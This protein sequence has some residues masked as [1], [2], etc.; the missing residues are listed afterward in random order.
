MATPTPGPVTSPVAVKIYADP[1]HAVEDPFYVHV[2]KNEEVVWECMQSHQHGHGKCFTI[3]FP[4]DSPFADKVF[5]DHG[6]KTGVAVVPPNDVK[7]YK[8][9]IKIPGGGTLDPQGGVKG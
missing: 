2:S 9:T 7:L 4:G 1:L 3:E 5:Q 6:A 8:Y